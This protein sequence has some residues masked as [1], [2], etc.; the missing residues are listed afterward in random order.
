V[1]AA[2]FLENLVLACIDE[3]HL[4]DEWGEEFRPSFKHVGPFFRG[5]LA[6]SMS[7]LA[8]SATLQ[9]GKDTDNI[10]SSLGFMPG[11][12]HHERRS[13]ERPNIQ[14]IFEQLSHGLGGSEFPDILSYPSGNRKTILYCA[15]IDKCF[16]VAAF[17]WRLLPPGPAKLK[18]VRLY[19]AMCWPDENDETTRFLRDDPECQVVIATIAFGHGFNV[20]P[21]LNSIRLGVATSMNRMEQ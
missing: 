20:K 5:C 7:I 16:R 13:N 9:P 2:S 10:C 8:L 6:S 1:D 11:S 17:L 15:T 12:F 19:H 4:I 18:R 14:F 21:A 3:V